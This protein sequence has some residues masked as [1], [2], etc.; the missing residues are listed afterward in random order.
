MRTNL[1]LE[2]PE[3]TKQ[4]QNQRHRRQRLLRSARNDIPGRL[5][6]ESLSVLTR[7][8]LWLSQY[9]LQTMSDGIAYTEA[10]A[11]MA[12]RRSLSCNHPGTSTFTQ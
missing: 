12:C 10:T 9:T 11:G 4:S 6:I 2:E 8:R 7:K 5:L 1:S 3:A